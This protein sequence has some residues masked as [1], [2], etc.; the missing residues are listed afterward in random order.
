MSISCEPDLVHVDV[1]L[2]FV[3][4]L[5]MDYSYTFNMSKHEDRYYRFINFISAPT[6]VSIH[7]TPY[8]HVT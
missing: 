3:D 1:W 6:F 8:M 2:L 5:S 4:E 7:N